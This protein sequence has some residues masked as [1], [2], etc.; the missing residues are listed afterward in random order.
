MHL[1]QARLEA[2]KVQLS[3]TG[4]KMLTPATKKRQTEFVS[5]VYQL[6]RARPGDVRRAQKIK[7]RVTAIPNLPEKSWLLEK[8][9]ALTGKA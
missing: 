6:L 9:E 4:P 8:A 7:D 1:F 3:R 2:F 5:F